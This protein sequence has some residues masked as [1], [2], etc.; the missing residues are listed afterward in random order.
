MQWRKNSDA[1]N[2][3]RQLL[4]DNRSALKVIA[5]LLFKVGRVGGYEVLSLIGHLRQRRHER[6]SKLSILVRWS[7]DHTKSVP[8]LADASGEQ[9]PS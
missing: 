2:S 7:R 9:I 4:Q 5:N 3:C 1:I 6:V 8:I